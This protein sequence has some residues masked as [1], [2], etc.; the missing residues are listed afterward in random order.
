M[1]IKR[2]L[3]KY[4][5]VKRYW[6]GIIVVLSKPYNLAI[7]LD[8]DNDLITKKSNKSEKI[9]LLKKKAEMIKG[10]IK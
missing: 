10:N 6:R 9:K 1:I 8:K 2:Y 7:T 3:N 5:K 4:I